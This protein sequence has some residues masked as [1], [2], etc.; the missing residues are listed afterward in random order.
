MP[1][2]VIRKDPRT[3]ELDPTFKSVD[4]GNAVDFA[5]RYDQEHIGSGVILGIDP[6]NALIHVAVRT[7]HGDRRWVDYNLLNGSDSNRSDCQQKLLP[8]FDAGPDKDQPKV[9]VW[10]EETIKFRHPVHR[11]LVERKEVKV[12]E[13]GNPVQATTPTGAPKS[14]FQR[15]MERPERNERTKRVYCRRSDLIK[16]AA[17]MKFGGADIQAV[18]NKAYPGLFTRTLAGKWEINR[19][20]THYDEERMQKLTFPIHERFFPKPVLV[21]FANIIG[22]EGSGSRWDWPGAKG[23]PGKVFEAFEEDGR[24][25]WPETFDEMQPKLKEYGNKVNLLL[26]RTGSAAGISIR[27]DGSIKIPTG[28]VSRPDAPYKV[29]PTFMEEVWEDEIMKVPL[30]FV[31]RRLYKTQDG[32]LEPEKLVHYPGEKGWHLVPPPD[33]EPTDQFQDE[34]NVGHLASWLKPSDEAAVAKNIK[35]REYYSSAL[36]IGGKDYCRRMKWNGLKEDMQEWF[37]RFSMNWC[38]FAAGATVHPRSKVKQARRLTKGGKWVGETYGSGKM[39]TQ[40]NDCRQMMWELRD[41]LAPAACDMSLKTSKNLLASLEPRVD[42][43]SRPSAETRSKGEV[44]RGLLETG[45]LGATPAPPG[46]KLPN[47][48][49]YEEFRRGV[50]PVYE[51][52]ETGKRTNLAGAGFKIPREVE[53]W[54]G[55]RGEDGWEFITGKVKGNGSS[56]PGNPRLVPDR[57]ILRPLGEKPK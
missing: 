15:K 11:T 10:E 51:D 7:G 29:G 26:A 21:P 13:Q 48:W 6:D 52:P 3:D 4:T 19:N 2:L 20:S 32:S 16:L 36:E 8:T 25:I 46:E 18:I 40:M 56:E 9:P 49:V 30:R 22:T 37:A 1:E 24:F 41:A 44:S 27:E 42:V 12:D 28:K 55:D 17:D 33:S 35:P 23:E 31:P 47:L 14:K 57:A 45:R 53:E 43:R 34:I 38:A 54:E 5:L 50:L 39:L